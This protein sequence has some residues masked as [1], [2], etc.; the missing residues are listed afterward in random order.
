LK[1]K[2]EF[3]EILINPLKNEHKSRD[4]LK[5][6]ERG[7]VPTIHDQGVIVSESIAI[8]QYLEQT[9]HENYL[10]PKK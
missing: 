2:V 5:I 6:N 9:Y 1:K 8:L 3:D 4:Y 10:M 7:E